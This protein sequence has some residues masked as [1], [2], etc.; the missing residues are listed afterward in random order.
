MIVGNP[1]GHSLWYSWT[2][3]ASGSVTLDT[4][5]SAFDTTLAVYTGSTLSGLSKLVENDDTSSSDTTSKVSF[6]ATAG[7][8]Y[9][10]QVD[11]YNGTSRPPWYG[12]LTLNWHM[13]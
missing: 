3:P 13:P 1:G 7:V 2:A 8:T 6:A 11:G 12:A 5:G 10:I 4:H 9:Q